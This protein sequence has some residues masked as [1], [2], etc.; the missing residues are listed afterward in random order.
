MVGNGTTGA[1]SD[2]QIGMGM[3]PIVKKIVCICI[4]VKRINGKMQIVEKKENVGLYQC[5]CA[6]SGRFEYHILLK[7]T[8]ISNHCI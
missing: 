8:L 4:T 6:K 3:N 7:F 2:I 1:H 5:F